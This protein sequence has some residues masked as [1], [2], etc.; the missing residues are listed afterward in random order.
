MVHLPCPHNDSLFGNESKLHDVKSPYLIDLCS[1]NFL[2][3]VRR[4]LL[5]WA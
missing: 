2:V 1:L 5:G 4:L 3:V